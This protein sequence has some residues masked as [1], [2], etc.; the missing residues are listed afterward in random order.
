M[1]PGVLASL[2]YCGA[3]FGGAFL[4]MRLAAPEL[5]AL[6]VAFGRVTIAAL[7]LLPLVGRGPLAA[8]RARWR[9][10]AVVGFFMAAA[11]FAL[12]AF[13][14]R[15]LT[16]GLG[17]IINA[18]TPLW[19]AIILAAWLR[20]A[21]TARRVAA[22]VIG[23]AGV[24][25]IVG[26]EGLQLAPDAYLGVVAAFLGAASYGLALIYIRQRLGPQPP[27]QLALGQLLAAVVMLTPLAALSACE[28]TVTGEALLALLGIGVLSTA[29]AWP[30]L[31][32]LNREVGPM[33]TSTVTFLNPVFGT[34]WGALFLGEAI[35]PTF[36]VGAL[37]VFVSLALILNVNPVSAIR[38]AVRPRPA[39]AVP[40]EADDPA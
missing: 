10:Y 11:P 7:I 27:V 8:M 39:P 19:T 24:G 34:L 17:S 22:I 6:I 36:L 28:V 23:F 3:A 21:P 25:V 16:A 18:T 31:F 20:Q 2:V 5:P 29:I 38:R 40:V 26:L 9:Q 15:S 35:S 14:E 32:R 33:A 4:F 1:S 37:L 30:L 13:A 12:F